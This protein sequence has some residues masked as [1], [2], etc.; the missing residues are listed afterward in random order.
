M[1]QD[2]IDKADTKG[3]GYAVD[4][5]LEIA[6]SRQHPFLGMVGSECRDSRVVNMSKVKVYCLVN[7]SHAHWPSSHNP[8]SVRLVSIPRSG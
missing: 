5:V 3:D 2:E 6:R 1:Q 4:L 7:V 8:F